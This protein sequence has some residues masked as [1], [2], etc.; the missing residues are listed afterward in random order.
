ML[1]RNGYIKR[2]DRMLSDSSKFKKLNIKPEKEINFLLQREG[3]LTNSS[4]NV[5]RSTSVQLHKELYPRGLQSSIIYVLFKI[6]KP[7][8]NNIRKLHSILSAINIATYG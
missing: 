7:L 2:L 4:K 6:H 8:I 1:N 5:K 3:R